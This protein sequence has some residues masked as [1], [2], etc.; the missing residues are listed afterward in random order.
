MDQQYMTVRVLVKPTGG[1][2]DLDRAKAV[3]A[4]LIADATDEEIRSIDD[5]SWWQYQTDLPYED[6]LDIAK[7][8]AAI[9]TSMMTLLRDISR[10]LEHPHVTSVTLG[11]VQVFITGG[12][13]QVGCWPTDD[14]RLWEL[15]LSDEGGLPEWWRSEILIAFGFLPYSAVSYTN[16]L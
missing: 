16:L 9:L 14:Y 6:T 10:S 12:V 4:A 1:N 3:A 11:G 15:L 8:R 5:T 2:L 7:L 13:D